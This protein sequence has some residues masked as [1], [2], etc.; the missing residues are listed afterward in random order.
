MGEAHG[1]TLTDFS[2][3]LHRADL[4]HVEKDRAKVTQVGVF[5]Q[6]FLEH[7]LI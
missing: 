3:L 1:L 4:A 7:I 5:Q 6:D 2:H